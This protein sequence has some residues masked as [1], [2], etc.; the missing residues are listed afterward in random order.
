MGKQ[1][2]L[3]RHIKIW[4]SNFST[5]PKQRA[6]NVLLNEK[7]Q[8]QAVNSLNLLKYEKIK[9]EIKVWNNQKKYKIRNMYGDTELIESDVFHECGLYDDRIESIAKAWNE[10]E[11]LLNEAGR[12]DEQLSK[13]LE[14]LKK[15]KQNLTDIEF[16][17]RI[18]PY[19]LRKFADTKTLNLFSK[20]R[21][22]DM[23]AETY[24]DQKLNELVVSLLAC[25]SNGPK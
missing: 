22:A 1:N 18:G 11:I 10:N 7:Q 15:R 8:E 20:F 17:V 6:L 14:E 4:V 21:K 13:E 9:G 5:E 2:P 12:R 25:W 3:K 19:E 23:S 16:F 24:T